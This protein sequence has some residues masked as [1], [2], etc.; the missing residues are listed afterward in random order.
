V[1]ELRPFPFAALLHRLRRELEAGGPVFGLSRKD[2]HI[3]DP[4][5]DL[6][7]RHAGRRAANP[8]GPAAGPHTQLAPNM[9]QGWLAGARIFELKTIQR[10]DRLEIPRPCIHAPNL[11]FNV[12]WS[13]ELRLE[14]SIREYQKASWL[15]AILRRTRA[16]GALPEAACLDT[17]LDLSVGYSLEGI[18]SAGMRRALESVRRPEG[19]YRELAEGLPDPLRAFAGDPPPGPLAD[20][21][22]LSTFHGCPPGEIE[23]IAM[24][25]LEEGWSVMVKLNPTLLGLEETRRLLHREL[26]YGDLELDPESFEK[27]LDLPSAVAMLERLRLEAGKRGLVAGAKF[28]NTLV[29]RNDGS[30]FPGQRDP[31]MYLSGPP[32][33]VLALAAAA[34]V[35]S[36]LQGPVP[37]SFSAGLDRGN[38]AATLRAGFGPLTL[39]TDLLRV[40]GQGRLRRVV[41]ALEDALR[42]SGCRSLGEWRGDPP[43]DGLEG[44]GATRSRVAELA[45][46]VEG[47]P[48]YRAEAVRREPRKMDRVLESLDCITCDLCLP[49]CP[50]LALFPWATP[51]EPGLKEKH[52]IGVLADAC[53]DCGNCA[54]RCPELGAPQEV[55]ERWH[56]DP[57]SWAAGERDGFCQDGRDLLGRV[58]GVVLR[59]TGDPDL[60]AGTLLVDGTAWEVR[61]GSL[62]P[63]DAAGDESPG[64]ELLPQVSAGS[65]IRREAVRSHEAVEAVFQRARLVW[66][67]LLHGRDHPVALLREMKEG[68]S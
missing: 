53:N 54:T 64:G 57:A 46:R 13:Q 66:R 65:R 27:D 35:V 41:G 25:L 44:W 10:L 55:K 9:V 40:G 62:L 32:L 18:R 50:N 33:H 39:C 19:G 22:T 37:L 56:Q 21:I 48:R 30:L 59:L 14:E 51:G 8:C 67:H 5:L 23:A 31:H 1:T 61:G 52:Q 20:C 29:L 43:W 15:L 7:F 63:T 3:P 26:G 68:S 38:A 11:A 47:D 28:T 58:G 24:H 17:V 49:A 60:G 34:R 2:W 4:A 12:E 45:A 42:E 6:S 36:R 16:G